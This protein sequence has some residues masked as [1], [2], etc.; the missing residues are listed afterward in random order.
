LAVVPLTRRHLLKM[1]RTAEPAW[2]TANSKTL[3]VQAR[4]TVDAA[5]STY[6]DDNL[7]P[8]VLI[9]RLLL[10][11][12]RLPPE[13][14]RTGVD[15][16]RELSD[17]IHDWS[18]RR[19][20]VTEWGL[21]PLCGLDSATLRTMSPELAEYLHKQA[22]Y[23]GCAHHGT[24]LGLA[25]EVNA[26][27]FSLVT[28]SE[29]DV[30]SL[31]EKLPCGVTPTDVL[32]VSRLITALKAPKNTLSFTLGRVF[33]WLRYHRPTVRLLLTYLDPNLGFSGAVYRATNWFLFATEP[34]RPYV[35]V[36]GE[37]VTSRELRDRYNLDD[38]S[39]PERTLGDRL[40]RSAIDLQPLEAY[41]YW[42]RRP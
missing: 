32:V 23:L 41:G 34:K 27:P 31:I 24:H 35:Y 19:I 1:V 21:E 12:Y 11:V 26:H 18:C 7:D 5:L 13:T 39:S 10:H 6:Q 14:L 42:L 40:S 30:E 28:L 22:H 25:C 20:N 33:A 29:L 16:E 3:I 17:V 8:R 15:W 36:D 38:W 4:E 2:L 37:Y 9:P